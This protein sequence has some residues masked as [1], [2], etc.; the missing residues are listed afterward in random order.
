[1]LA[2][3]LP[4]QAPFFVLRGR[5]PKTAK[6]ILTGGLLAGAIV[7]AGRMGLGAHYISDIL[8]AAAIS[9]GTAALAAPLMARVKHIKPWLLAAGIL[10]AGAGMLLGN[11]F[12]LTLTAE[13]P[14]ALRRYNLPCRIEAAPVPG[15]ITPTLVVNLQG[16][17][18][19]VSN[20]KLVQTAEG[21]ELQ[22]GVGIF[23]SLTCTAK[24]HLPMAAAE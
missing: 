15:T 22:R 5:R 16:F 6:L 3:P 24:L 2:L 17:G 9:L 1:M 19:P 10:L 21:L 4:L 13:L 7:G 12:K 18:A 8:I 14:Q 23:H 11:H 20:L